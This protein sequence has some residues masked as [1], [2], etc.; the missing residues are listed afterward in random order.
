MVTRKSTKKSA[1]KT[2]AKKSATKKTATKKTASKGASKAAGKTEQRFKVGD[3]VRWD[4]SSGESIGKI[5]KVATT[6]GRIKDFEYTASKD[7]PRYI[8]ETDE[9]KHAAHKAVESFKSDR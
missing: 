3:R 9:G 1:T 6:G 2:S 4:S 8:V 5:V 7:D